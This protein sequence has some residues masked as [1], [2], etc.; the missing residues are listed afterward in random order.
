MK[1]TLIYVL[2]DSIENSVFVGQ[3]LI[4]LR[5]K[6]SASTYQQ[7]I[8]IS[9]EKKKYTQYEIERI[10]APDNHLLCIIL[11]QLPFL[12]TVTLYPA[13]YQL[14]ALLKKLP[15][16]AIIAR[17]AVAGYICLK[18]HTPSTTSLT[19]QARGLLA[20]E[21]EFNHQ[22]TNR[23]RKLLR[24]LRTHLFFTLEKK[25]YA[26]EHNVIIEAVSPALAQYLMS[27]FN[28]QQKMIRI[29]HTDIPQHIDKEQIASWRSTTR[30]AL[31]IASHAK[32]YCY[33]GSI[34]PWQCP[35]TV[36]D[37]FM[38]ESQTNPAAFLLVITQNAQEFTQKLRKKGTPQQ[39]YRV[40]SVP[41]QSIYQHLAAADIGLIFRKSHIVNW[42]SRPT[43]VLEYQAV[44]LPIIHNNT[45]EWICSLPNTI[46]VKV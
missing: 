44:G 11:P 3:V 43:K 25:T 27:T 16:H 30:K 33:N 40:C 8:I 42:T 4:P 34:K 12:G 45:V 32:V 39:Q 38:R 41:Y 36:I 7:I 35:D 24:K 2:Y 21:Y 18:A 1:H 17:G 9:F 31:D 29:A 6:L 5:A 28:A 22:T 20:A 13:I 23:L 19:I 37:F 15:P 14:Q 46:V 10:I 26:S